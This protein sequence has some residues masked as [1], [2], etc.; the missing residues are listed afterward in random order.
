[1]NYRFNAIRKLIY[2]YL[3]ENKQIRLIPKRFLGIRYYR[4]VPLDNEVHVNLIRHL[5]DLLLRGQK[6]EDEDY[7]ILYL[8]K[9][10][11]IVRSLSDMRSERG[12]DS[13]KFETSY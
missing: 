9:T 1:M 8:I 11:N 4:Y 2:A 7:A 10:T 5:R 12:S 6:P 13:A 3:A